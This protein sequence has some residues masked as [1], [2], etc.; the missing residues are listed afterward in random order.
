[1]KW[2]NASSVFGPPPA[3]NTKRT[4]R[5]DGEGVSPATRRALADGPSFFARFEGE[6]RE[7]D[8]AGQN[9]LDLG[10]GYGGR[11]IYCAREGGPRSVVGL[12]VSARY[13]ELAR[14]S[15]ER[16]C[17]SSPPSFLVAS[18]EE[19][20]IAAER[21]DVVLS[22]DVFEHVV[23]LA[24]VLRECHRVLRPGGTLYAV[25]PPY[26]GPRAH[27]L[28]FITTMPFLHHAFSADT[29][30][31]AANRLLVERPDIRAKSVRAPRVGARRVTM[32]T[33]NGT[34]ERDFRDLVAGS[35]FEVV[36]LDLLP[37]AWS[38]GDAAAGGSPRRGG[39]RRLLAST[40][41]GLLAMPVPFPRDVFASS[42]RCVLR[43]PRRV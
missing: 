42:I 36:R 20:P 14:A 10:C 12:D 5:P 27:H 28:D 32:P 4:E 41:R 24:A 31:E 9:V 11:S 30:V 25:F 22:Y 1:M 34:T 8:L 33:L 2:G 21:F 37:F 16:L 7:R 18:A 39:P 38:P 35:P 43:K 19:I 6:L 29:L 26:F 40:C 13:V 15:A 3:V 17:P 23:D